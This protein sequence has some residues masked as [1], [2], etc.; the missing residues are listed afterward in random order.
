[1]V[2][3]IAIEVRWQAEFQFRWTKIQPMVLWQQSPSSFHHWTLLSFTPHRTQLALPFLSQ[4]IQVRQRLRRCR[5]VAAAP[6]RILGS[7]RRPRQ[8]EG[9]SF[10]GPVVLGQHCPSLGCSWPK[11][12]WDFVLAVT[13]IIVQ[14]Y[15]VSS[16]TSR[17]GGVERLFSSIHVQLGHVTHLGQ[18][19][20]LANWMLVIWHS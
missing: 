19:S 17:E 1:M 20:L 13:W 2:F 7:P 8:C 12:K 6:C 18:F 15:S 9:G 3:S 16:P 11:Q 4:S 14:K 5:G 10:R